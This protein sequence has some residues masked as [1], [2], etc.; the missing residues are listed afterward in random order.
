MT[1]LSVKSTGENSV[2]IKVCNINEARNKTN[3]TICTETLL[4]YV[5]G[6]SDGR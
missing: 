6:K 4:F 5:E 2:F 3:T 1:E